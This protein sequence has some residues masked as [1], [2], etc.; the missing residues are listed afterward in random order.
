M[1]A[2]LLARGLGRRMQQDGGV[3]LTAAQQAAAAGGATAARSDP[4]YVWDL[5]TLF[6]D[7]AA[8]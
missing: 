7:D 3:A 4:R 8:W 2:L 6:K 5:S 1:K